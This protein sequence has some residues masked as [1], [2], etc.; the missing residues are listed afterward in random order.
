MS[1]EK[2]N[3]NFFFAPNFISVYP[4]EG[5]HQ[6]WKRPSCIEELED[7][8]SALLAHEKL[9]PEELESEIHRLKSVGTE[10]WKLDSDPSWKPE[11]P[12]LF[13]NDWGEW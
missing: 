5:G 13:P 4:P 9:S 6:T 10:L 12:I 7:T 1:P 2:P 8:I 11:P 3:I